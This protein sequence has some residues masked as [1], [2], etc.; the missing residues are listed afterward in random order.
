M[1]ILQSL[2]L[3]KQ[4]EGLETDPTINKRNRLAARLDEQIALAQD[5]SY[6]P[7]AIKRVTQ[8]DGTVATVERAKRL[9]PW[10]QVT[11]KGEVELVIKYGTKKLELAKGKNAVKLGTL[12][13][14]LPTLEKLKDAV[15]IGEL[16]AVLQAQ[17]STAKRAK[18]A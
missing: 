11:S 2:T 10:W 18:A 13:D 7:I 6:T 15:L 3:T 16:D 8:S 1:S 4:T 9:K 12:D 17:V 5:P 14:V